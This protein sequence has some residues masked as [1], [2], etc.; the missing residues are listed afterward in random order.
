MEGITTPVVDPFKHLIK[1]F[2]GTPD[3]AVVAI[4]ADDVNAA[5]VQKAIAELKQKALASG[6]MHARSPSTST[7]AGTVAKVEI[8]L[9]GN[10]VDGRSTA[11]AQHPAARPA[12][13]RPWARS[14]ASS[15]P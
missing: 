7:A 13:R 6:E 8:P 1:A 15:T 4:K 11:R 5:P 9:A 3:P 14:T 2:P 10:G 12:A